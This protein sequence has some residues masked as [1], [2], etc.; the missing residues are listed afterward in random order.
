MER[1]IKGQRRYNTE[2]AKVQAQFSTGEASTPFWY[3]ETLYRKKSGE[4]FLHGIGQIYSK[5]GKV[6]NGKRVKGEE[7][8]PLTYEEAK[9]WASKHLPPTEYDFLFGK[10]IKIGKYPCHLML[11]ASTAEK[12]RRVASQT[13][14]QQAEI[15]AELIEKYL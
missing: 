15:V 4:Y 7:I 13:G 8:I 14:R 9:D 5:Y 1:I 11:P 10:I 3:M 2:T 6:I 12:L